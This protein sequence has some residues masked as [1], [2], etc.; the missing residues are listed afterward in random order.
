MFELANL[1]DARI[2]AQRMVN[3]ISRGEGMLSFGVKAE[4]VALDRLGSEIIVELARVAI[5]LGYR[6]EKITVDDIARARVEH[7]DLEKAG[8]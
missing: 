5:A 7:H 2:P 1:I 6:V 8:A 3:V 4:P